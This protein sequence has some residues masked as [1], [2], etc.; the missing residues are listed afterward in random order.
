MV[1]K[2]MFSLFF[3]FYALDK[4]KQKKENE[5][6]AREISDNV[7]QETLQQD[8]KEK[9]RDLIVLSR[10]LSWRGHAVGLENHHTHTHTKKKEKQNL[11]FQ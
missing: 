10:L 1:I 11:R 9:S 7:N 5:D 4:A 6:I 3:S 8:Q 2:S